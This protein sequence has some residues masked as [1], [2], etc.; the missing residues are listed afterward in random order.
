V[1]AA[2]SGITGGLLALSLGVG[3]AVEPDH[4]AAVSTLVADLRG[5]GR[6]VRRAALLGLSWGAGHTLAIL[7][8]GLALGGLRATIPGRLDDL[9]ELVVAGTLLVL[10]GRA[11]VRAVRAG[12][13]GPAHLHTHGAGGVHHVHSGPSDHVHLGRVTLARQPLVV[14]LLHGL[15][16]SGALAASAFAAIPNHAASFAFLLLFGA[17]ATIGMAGAAALGGLLSARL[18][19]G[20]RASIALVAVAGVLSLALGAVKGWP[21][22][23]RLLSS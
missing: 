16:G 6:R 2:L 23:L 11:I 12:R 9:F 13:S 3:H 8:V 10:G 22:A 1:L 14:G 7:A 4:L 19:A 18:A 5:A 15:A 17:G 21:L 20:R